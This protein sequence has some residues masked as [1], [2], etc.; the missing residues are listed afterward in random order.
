MKRAPERESWGNH[1]RTTLTFICEKSLVDCENK[2]LET[3][4]LPLLLDA[5]ESSR[6]HL[7]MDKMRTGQ[8]VRHEGR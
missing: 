1:W 2:T 5:E 8:V 6:S 3:E 7:S 4:C